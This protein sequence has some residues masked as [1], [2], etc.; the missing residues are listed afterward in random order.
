MDKKCKVCGKAYRVPPSHDKRYKNYCSAKCRASSKICKNCEACGSQFFVKPS[1]ADRTRYCSMKC[2][3]STMLQKE[4]ECP[5]CGCVFTSTRS[6]HPT[7]DGMRI[8]CSA[9]CANAARS[10]KIERICAQCGNTFLL[11][12]ATDKQR[13]NGVCCS[14]S[15]STAFYRAANSPAFKGG[16]H[17]PAGSDTR[18]VLFPRKGKVGKYFGQHRLVASKAIGRLLEQ[19]EPVIHINGDHSDNRPENLFICGSNSEC[20][21]RR[22]GSLPWPK[23]SNLDTYEKSN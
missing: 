20:Q 15:C 6:S 23:K 3:K 2:R 7:E 18:Y 12:P 10:T 13:A 17:I 19:H 8:Y 5:N 9:K 16:I 14:R 4:K 11:S 21:R 22:Y 1:R